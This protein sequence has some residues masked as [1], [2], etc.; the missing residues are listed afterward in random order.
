MNVSY[1]VAGVIFDFISL[2]KT[3]LFCMLWTWG[4]LVDRIQTIKHIKNIYL[5]NINFNTFTSNF[6][7]IRIG[8]EPGGAQAPPGFEDGP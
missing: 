8:A 7:A 5:I 3:G 6:F 4:T 1:F 2:I